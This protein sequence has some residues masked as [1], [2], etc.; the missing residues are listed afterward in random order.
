LGTFSVDNTFTYN[1]SDTVGPDGKPVPG[2]WRGIYRWLLDTDRPNL[3]PWEMLG[4]SIEPKWWATVY[5]VGPYTGDNF[6]M[7]QD[8][9]DGMVREPGVPAV[10]LSK[11]VK[12]F[13][14][15]HIPV[16]SNGILLSPVDSGLVSGPTNFTMDGG[17]VFG[18]VNP[19]ESAWRRSSHYPFSVLISAILLNP[20]KTFGLLLDRA[21]IKRNLAGQLIY[22][23]TNLRVR[24]TDIV[25]PSIYS[26]TTRVQTAGLVN[27]IVD[28]ILNFVFSNNV[29]S[30]NQYATD[31]DTLTS[32]I[33]YRVGAFTSKEQFNLLL[34]S[35]TPLSTGSVF[36]P[37]ENYQVNINTCVYNN[38]NGVSIG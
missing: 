17:F 25:L 32:Q 8:I 34:D 18:D 19:V 9:S 11:Y 7:W 14:M 29:R 3:C 1:Y 5:G 28:H 24:P 2:Y 37:Q 33:S 31:L 35:K 27:Y 26:S 6:P 10:K 21:N 12:P 13:L 30:Y 4:F 22:T 38:V 36:I 23:N 20:A 15:S 16:D